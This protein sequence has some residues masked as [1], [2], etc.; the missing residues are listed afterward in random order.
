MKRLDCIGIS[1]FCELTI[2]RTP[3]CLFLHLAFLAT[4]SI[5]VVASQD[6]M[7][8]CTVEGELFP[9]LTLF[10]CF[11]VPLLILGRFLDCFATM[12]QFFA[13]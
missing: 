2:L 3:M 8:A 5:K 6:T 9:P 10:T 11:F 12:R 13:A 7:S 1:I 4:V